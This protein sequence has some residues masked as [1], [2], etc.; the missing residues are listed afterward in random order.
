MLELE[1]KPKNAEEAIK[2][3]WKT[4]KEMYECACVDRRTWDRFIDTIKKH[5]SETK[6]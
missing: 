3:G 5:I 6:F 2:A 4:A 1:N